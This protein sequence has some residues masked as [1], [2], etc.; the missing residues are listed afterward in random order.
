MKRKKMTKKKIGRRQIK[1]LHFLRFFPIIIFQFGFNDLLTKG[2]ISKDNIIESILILLEIN[3]QKKQ[4]YLILSI[5]LTDL[6]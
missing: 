6:R 2:R 1:W 3:V 4:N 5:F